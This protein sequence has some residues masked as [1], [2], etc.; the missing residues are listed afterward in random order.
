[1][2]RKVVTPAQVVYLSYFMD[3]IINFDKTFPF[4]AKGNIFYIISLE[5]K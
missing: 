5:D 3:N 2:R 1:M 4:K